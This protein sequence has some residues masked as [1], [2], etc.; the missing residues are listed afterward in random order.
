MR[1]STRQLEAFLL[2]AEVR[3]FTRA[4]ETLHVTQAGLSSMV[5]ELEIQLGTRLFER[6][7]RPLELTSAGAQFLPYARQS[8]ES[9]GRGALELSALTRREQGGIRIGV[10]PLIAAS[11][12]PEVVQAFRKQ[13]RRTCEVV[14]AEL[15]VL[16]DMVE[17]GRLDACYGTYVQRTSSLR[18]DPIFGM[19]L[20][21]I[22]PR[23]MLKEPFEIRTADDWEKLKDSVLWV[24]PE[25]N[26]VQQVVN[27]Y[28][29]EANAPAFERQ[30]AHHVVTIMAFISAGMGVG[31]VPDFLIGLHNQDQVSCIPIRLPPGRPEVD[32]YCTR[33]TTGRA[34]PSIDVFSA[35]LTRKCSTALPC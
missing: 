4:A 29:L 13:T 3:S 25:S 23:G 19:K 5:N 26:A 7:S 32:F 34:S 20:S 14:D 8:M 31:F 9:L 24:L 28:M 1:V 33:D 11:V 22:C 16:H 2:V 6:A 10:S 30:Q 27:R 21:L 12:L 17:S 15:D 35:L 18:S